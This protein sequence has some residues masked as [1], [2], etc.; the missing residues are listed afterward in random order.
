MMMGIKPP[1]G[2]LHDIN[3][4][5]KERSSVMHDHGHMFYGTACP[6]RCGKA[7]AWSAR[8]LITPRGLLDAART[9][10][11]FDGLADALLV[12]PADVTAYLEDL[13]A[14]EWLNMSSLIGRDLTQV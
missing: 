12:T 3:I 8:R 13:D 10:H 2:G 7:A 9:T 4:H 6:D 1:L 14:D 11:G 5:I